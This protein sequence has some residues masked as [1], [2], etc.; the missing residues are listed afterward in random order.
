MD[1]LDIIA[2][3]A[4]DYTGPA[5]TDAELETAAKDIREALD[6]ATKA[7]EPELDLAKDLAEAL[8]VVTK[9]ADDRE[10]AREE[11]RAEAKKLRE[12][13][14]DDTP[15]T[16]A[17]ET[18]VEET[19][20]VEAEIKEPVAAAGI[21]ERLKR[22]AATK[23][24]EQEKP[25]TMGGVR[26]TA[27]GP[28]AGYDVGTGTF[29]DLG[30]MF[31]THAKSVQ[32][33]GKSDRLFRLTRDFDES[34]QLG[35]NVEVNNRRI[36]DVFGYGQTSRPVAA[37]GGLCGPGEVDF[38]HPICADRG[39]PV[40]DSLVQFNAA[41]GQVTYSPAAGLGDVDGAVSIWTPAMD[42]AAPASGVKPC[43]PV[44]C[45]EELTAAVD[46]VTRCL[47]IGNFQATFSPELWA[48]RLEL[49]LA[50]HD[51]VA[52][53]K[54]LVE[55]HEGSTFIAAGSL[56]DGGNVIANFLENINTIVAQD[57]AIQR[58]L[59][60]QYV[61]L[62]DSYVRD[63]IRNQVIRNMG[64]ANN[65][66]TIQIADAMIAGWL[67]DVNVRAVWT[68]DG[69]VDEQT[70][71]HNIPTAVGLPLAAATVYVYPEDAWMFLDGGT[72]DLGTQITDSSLNATND[73]Q[74]FAETFEKTAFRGCSSYAFEL[75]TDIAC[76][77]P[78]P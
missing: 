20:V 31:S 28:A 50:L 2:K 61:V 56:V 17:E 47:T 3:L 24:P 53:Q 58:N 1:P 13:I 39:R 11:R 72:L 46:A 14:F 23:A 30:K 73:R 8:Q 76:G 71:D 19:P 36:T 37:A 59:T 16:P 55:I 69:T 32:G 52:E 6:V 40:R 29:A 35:F 65:A 49:L 75:V 42:A 10:S 67:A 78:T 63:A 44:E 15:E 21:I 64:V 70:G 51:R 57:R 4:E 9:A 66:E 54:S 25:K 60:G 18:P 38:S 41:R 12:G 5:P 26:T 62:T 45:P 77:C 34:R 7:D 68:V 22:H 48:S 74:A 43:P 33:I 27:V